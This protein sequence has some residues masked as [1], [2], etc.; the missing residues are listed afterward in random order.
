[1]SP[2]DIEITVARMYLARPD[3]N[4]C[5]LA[6]LDVVVADLLVIRDVRIIRTGGGKVFVAFPSEHVK[7]RCLRCGTKVRYHRGLCS[8]CGARDGFELPPK[9]DGRSSFRKD[10]V[11][12]I[13][14]AARHAFEL[15]I[16][17]AYR[18]AVARIAGPA[19]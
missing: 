15:V 3:D 12:P 17:D 11:F 5:F 19:P 1:V 10:V 8:W 2:D 18:E 13:T 6:A 7:V 4:E 16:M 9:S 14:P